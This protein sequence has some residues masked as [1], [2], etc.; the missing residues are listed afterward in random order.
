MHYKLVEAI[1][2]TEDSLNKN[3]VMIDVYE[4]WNIVC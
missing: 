2:N 1:L 3:V 4:V